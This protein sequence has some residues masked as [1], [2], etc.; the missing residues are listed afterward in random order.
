MTRNRAL[1]LERARASQ[2]LSSSGVGR[3]SLYE[4]RYAAFIE[5]HRFWQINRAVV[6]GVGG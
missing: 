4:A 1:S 5:R 2:Y 3:F 6:L